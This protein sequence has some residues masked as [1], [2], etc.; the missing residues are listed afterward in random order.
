LSDP[1]R[2]PRTRTR[3]LTIAL[4]LLIGA[5]VIGAVIG[6][7]RFYWP[8][9]AAIAVRAETAPVTSAEDAADDPAIYVHRADPARSLVVG[10]DKQ[11]KTGGLHVYDLAGNEVFAVNNG[12]QNNVDL[13][14]DFPFAD[15]PGPLVVASG[16]RLAKILLYRLDGETGRLDRLVA[17]T[18][19]TGI[20][21]EGICLYRSAVDGRHHVFVT[22][23][24]LVSG[25]DGF[26]EQYALRVLGDG[27]IL[28]DL[29]RRF[30]VGGDIEG[31]VADD[32]LGY[33]YVSE[34]EVAVWR[35]P[36][37]PD[38]GDERVAIDRIGAA[39]N[40]RYHAEG[41]AIFARPDGGGQIIVSS[42]GSDDFT[43]YDRVPPHAYRGRFGLAGAGGIDAVTH[44][45]GIDVT[46]AALGPPFERGLFVAQDNRNEGNQNFKYASYADVETALELE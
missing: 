46:S 8:A 36:G 20:D 34:E 11:P 29:V 26:V 15:G 28:G 27:R 37:E 5:G 40:L 23:D 31:C 41:I 21:A 45:D 1:E 39:G 12:G 9:G 10:T 7:S 22:G 6:G 2:V 13:R 14:D 42:Q 24:D 32:A 4:A 19:L 3:R 18:I 38:G 30:D 35:Y 44:T 16:N 25:E 17:S 43:V 33:F